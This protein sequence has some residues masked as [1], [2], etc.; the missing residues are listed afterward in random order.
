MSKTIESPVKKFPGTVTIAS[1]MFHPQVRAILQ[2]VRDAKEDAATDRR[3]EILIA[4]IVPSVESSTIAGWD[5]TAD[6]F[7]AT[8]VRSSEK[9]LY[10]LFE[11]IMREVREDDELPLPASP[12][13]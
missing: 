9:L 4:G 5:G 1:P 12:P 11:E 3:S 6:H 2:A 13:V 7:P 10:W 8:P